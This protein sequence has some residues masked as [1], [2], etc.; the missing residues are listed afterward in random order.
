MLTTI[1]SLAS[2]DAG[3]IPIG[4]FWDCIENDA[5]N[6]YE[7]CTMLLSYMHQATK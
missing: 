3:D 2:V 4:A 6:H 1:S 7:Y 5:P